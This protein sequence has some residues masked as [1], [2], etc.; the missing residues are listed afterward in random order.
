VPPFLV[1]GPLTRKDLADYYH[2]VSRTDFYLGRLREEIKAQGIEENTYIVYCTDNGRPFPRCKTRLYDSGIKS[3]FIM[4]CPK[5]IQPARTDSF[6]SIIDVGPT[7]LE[8][9]G[10]KKD[11]RIQGVSFAPI[12]KNPKAKVRDYVFAE[13]NWHVYQAHERMVRAGDWLYIR[14]AWPERQ[15]LCVESV[16]KF[17]AGQELW[18]MQAEGK[19]NKSQG[20]LFLAPRPSEELYNVKTDP[21]QLN[22]LAFQEKEEV[23]KTL[24]KALD[25]WAT[26]TGDSVPKNPTNDREDSNGKKYKNHK[27]GDMPGAENNATKNSN[28][29][30]LL[31]AE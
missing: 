12:L 4:A 7:F 10:V 19:L 5:K 15:I 1:D 2:E 30:P 16:N 6:I 21:F 11:P 23:M 18:A 17:P 25:H 24:R 28:P 27:R 13:H 26:D 31:S 8:L 3:P 9:A 14:N 29:G 22:N 20:D